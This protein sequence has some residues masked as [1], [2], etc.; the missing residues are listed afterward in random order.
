MQTTL[1]VV[2]GVLVFAF[3]IYKI[4][5]AGRSKDVDRSLW[6]STYA[7]ETS[8]EEST[9]PLVMK[10]DVFEVKETLVT[11]ATEPLVTPI[12]DAPKK[13]TRKR[14]TKT[15]TSTSAEVMPSS[16]DH[17]TSTVNMISQGSVI[18]S[19]S[20]SASASTSS[21]SSSS[22]DSSCSSSSSSYD[23]GSSCDTSSGS[24]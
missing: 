14:S 6:T 17:L 13:P 9:K 3:V 5:T 1:A 7:T 18:S 23:S 21:S 16:V 10:A 22:Y 19:V 8:T 24:Y 20:T 15:T 12:A 4:A 2:V 11:P